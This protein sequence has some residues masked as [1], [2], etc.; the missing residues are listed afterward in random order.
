LSATQHETWPDAAVQQWPQARPEPKIDPR[1]EASS[2]EWAEM[3][4]KPFDYSES[5]RSIQQGK[6]GS[7][8]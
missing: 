2:K 6:G 1:S 5:D 4:E 8:A 3:W 7:T